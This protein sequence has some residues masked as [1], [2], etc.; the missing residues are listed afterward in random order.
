MTAQP[1]SPARSL[2]GDAALLAFGL[3]ISQGAVLLTYVA[4]A[5]LV[6]QAEVGTYQQLSLVYSIAA[7]LFLGGIPAALLYFMPRSRDRREMQDWLVRAFVL[8]AAFGLACSLLAVA[9]RYPL[10]SLMN[11]PDL[12][13]ALVLYAPYIGFA[14]LIYSAPSALI[15]AGRARAA[16]LMSVLAGASTLAGVVTAALI[17]PNARSLAAGVSIAGGVTAI[18]TC[19]IVAR[20]IPVARR[21]PAAATTAWLPLL[22]FGLPIALGGVAARVGYQF[23]RVVVGANFSPEEFAIYA[24]GAIEVPVSL[25]LQQAITNVLAPAL[26]T[27]WKE[28]D[29]GGLIALWREALRKT[30]LVVAPMFTFL[31]VMAPDLVRVV[32]GSQYSE[33]S[34]IF[35]IYLLFLPLR[36]ATWGLIPQAAGR[37]RINLIAGLLILPVNV[38]IALMLVGPLGLK[39]PAYAAPAAALVAT[40]YYLIRTRDILSTA[41]RELLPVRHAAACFAVTAIV[42][43]AIVPFQ[44]LDVSSLVRLITSFCLFGPLTL[45]AFRRLGL[46]NDDDWTR[47]RQLGRRTLASPARRRWPR[48]RR[49]DRSLPNEVDE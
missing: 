31:M 15:A 36:I 22:G 40:I 39:G 7:P 41:V 28:G 48:H 49:P 38:V 10:A 6:P 33:S 23:D 37:T 8:L 27:R 26:A 18:V 32:Y 12:A 47:L 17:S 44:S 34:D 24:L 30:T 13:P 29:V 19:A 1:R 9:L 5:R 42:G 46:I 14:F 45:F 16:A 43:A 20:T 35:R 21:W 3:L 25:L 11:N 4:A 2:S